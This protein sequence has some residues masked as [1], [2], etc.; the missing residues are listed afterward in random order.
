[1][2][3]FGKR[4]HNEHDL[5]GQDMGNQNGLVIEPLVVCHVPRQERG[6][7]DKENNVV[8]SRRDSPHPVNKYAAQEKESAAQKKNHRQ[9][10][11]GRFREAPDA[12]TPRFIKEDTVGQ[13]KNGHD[14][15]T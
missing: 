4:G 8:V 7:G 11:R 5:S 14:K 3:Q 13:K 12:Y 1:M 15:K 9:H 6:N 2:S 10:I